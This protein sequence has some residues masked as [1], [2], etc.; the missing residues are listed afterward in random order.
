[1]VIEMRPVPLGGNY[2]KGM[3]PRMREPSSSEKSAGTDRELQKLRRECASRL[4]A[5]RAE[6]DQHRWSLPTC[7]TSEHKSWPC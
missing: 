3:V 5:D 1:M 7:Y 2:E 4:V 6:K